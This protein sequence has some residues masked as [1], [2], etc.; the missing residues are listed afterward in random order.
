M[1]KVDAY[2]RVLLPACMIAAVALSGCMREPNDLKPELTNYYP[3]APLDDE[4][5]CTEPKT[6][7]IKPCDHVKKEWE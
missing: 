6:G 7:V 5:M 2:R 3:S 4:F 1:M